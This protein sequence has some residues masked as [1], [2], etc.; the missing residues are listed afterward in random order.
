MKLNKQKDEA[1]KNVEIV[2][3]TLQTRIMEIKEKL[4]IKNIILDCSCIN[5]IDTQ[6]ATA[7]VQLSESFNEIGIKLHLSFCKRKK[8]NTIKIFGA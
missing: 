6:G 5:N 7:F 3:E 2:T 1:S 4:P 8:F